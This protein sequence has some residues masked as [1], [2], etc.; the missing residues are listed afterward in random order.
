MT[1]LT[2]RNYFLSHKINKLAK[3]G[4]EDTKKQQ[5]QRKKKMV[6]ELIVKIFRSIVSSYSFRLCYYMSGNYPTDTCMR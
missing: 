4:C 3:E 1:I 5:K 6:N 2:S